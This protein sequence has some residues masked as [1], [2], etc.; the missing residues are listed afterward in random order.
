VLGKRQNNENLRAGPN[1]FRATKKLGATVYG[2]IVVLMPVDTQQHPRPNEVVEMTDVNRLADLPP[3]EAHATFM[4]ASAKKYLRD[5]YAGLT[6]TPTVRNALERLAAG[7][8]Q[9]FYRPVQ[10][11]DVREVDDSEQYSIGYMVRYDYGEVTTN[12]ANDS[13]KKIGEVLQEYFRSLG[14]AV[15]ELSVTRESA[16]QKFMEK[17]EGAGTWMLTKAGFDHDELKR[18][19]DTGVCLAD[20]PGISGKLD[21]F[22]TISD[23]Q[24]LPTKAGCMIW[25]DF[26]KTDDSNGSGGEQQDKGPKCFGLDYNK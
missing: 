13:L 6:Q 9:I 18:K 21:K 24:L 17:V 26:A 20:P 4:A 2:Y 10:L 3:E 19:R 23:S 15:P 14:G 8:V 11:G 22:Y 1:I 25:G 12:T 16:I 5:Y 7:P